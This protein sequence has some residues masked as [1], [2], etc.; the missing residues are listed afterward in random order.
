MYEA[1]SY[2]FVSDV[3]NVAFRLASLLFTLQLLTRARKVSGTTPWLHPGFDVTSKIYSLANISFLNVCT[4]SIISSLLLMKITCT[5]FL[6]FKLNISSSFVLLRVKS[7]IAIFFFRLL[8][9]W[10]FQANFDLVLQSVWIHKVFEH[11]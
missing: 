1:F 10:L 5:A 7:M 11:W 6:I 8:L 2:V 9:Y 4:K 3:I